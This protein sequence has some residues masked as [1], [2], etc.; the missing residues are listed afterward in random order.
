[1]EK[2]KSIEK[3]TFVRKIFLTLSANMDT[4]AIDRKRVCGFRRKRRPLSDGLI[5]VSVSGG[6][7]GL[8]GGLI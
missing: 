3:Q 7:D 8:G 6:Q 2:K 5:R 1:M 4:I